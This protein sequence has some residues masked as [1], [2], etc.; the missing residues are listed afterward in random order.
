MSDHAAAIPQ[1]SWVLVTG[2]NGYT[3]SHIVFEFLKR[4]FKVR[5]TVR[6]LESSQWLL[7]DDLAS[8][9]AKRG[10]L[11][12]VVAD[13]SKPNDYDKAVQGVAAVVHVAILNELVADPNIAIPATVESALSVC[14]S[15]AKAPSVKR[16]VFTSTFWANTFPTPDISETIAHDTWNDAAVKAAWAPPPYEADRI[17]PVYFAAKAEA[18]KA[19]WKFVKDEKLPWVVN[20]V[21]P[22]VILG[23]IRDDKHLRSVPPQLV[24]Q[25]YL[26]NTTK[27][28][29]PA[30]VAVVYVAAVLDEEVQGQRI[31][32]LAASFMWND[33]LAILRKAYPNRKFVDNF[34][35]GEPKLTYKIENDIAP[36]LVKKWAGRDWISLETT[37][38]ET[39]DYLIL[40]LLFAI[41]STALQAIRIQR[42]DHGIHR[43]KCAMNKPVILVKRRGRG[44]L[45]KAPAGSNKAPTSGLQ[46]INTAHPDESTSVNSIKLIR[47]H[48]AKQ[49]RSSVKKKQKGY[50]PST[51]RLR[52]SGPVD[53]HSDNECE[54][55]NIVR[56]EKLTKEMSLANRAGYRKLIPKQACQSPTR[57]QIGY[58]T[59]RSP[60]P[61]QLI[62]GAW[63]D[64]H[65]GFARRISDDEQFL[66]DF[67]LNYVIMYGYKTCY[68]EEDEDSFRVLMKETWFPNAMTQESLIAA[69][70]HVACRNYAT[71]TNNGLSQKFSV[72]KLQYRL[73]CLRM[74][75]DAINTEIIPTDAT[76]ALILLLS[77]E[78]VS[79]RGS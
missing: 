17:L 69:I 21:S 64:A 38:L 61:V 19:V 54:P 48:A 63:K 39:V 27:L 59:S 26:G 62:G 31:K 43:D 56:E 49:S 58:C 55:A 11:E 16:F 79:L 44:R 14:R 77:S 9:Y 18:E 32:V 78:S 28:Q 41:S 25:L 76:I 75:Q 33:L 71:I 36:G 68:K 6:D 72:K 13:T 46:F 5:G 7:N 1:G 57:K 15:A 40:H 37:L 29:T 73:T 47:S 70:L 2:A 53:G 50:T 51:Q 45:P 12:L 66:L 10:D 22:C 67:Y 52:P 34:I 3:G 42:K 24:E 65:T 23:D 35:S 74:A 4:G 20:S 60:S 30:Y 8:P